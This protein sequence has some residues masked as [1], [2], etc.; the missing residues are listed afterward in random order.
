MIGAVLF[1][2][3]KDLKLPPHKVELAGHLAVMNITYSA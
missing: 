2:I 3:V 1:N